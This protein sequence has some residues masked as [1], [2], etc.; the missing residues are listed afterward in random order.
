MIIE[1]DIA[2]S[3]SKV[4]CFKCQYC[5]NCKYWRTPVWNMWILTNKLCPASTYSFNSIFEAIENKK[6]ESQYTL[7]SAW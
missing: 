5:Y 7:S 1:E 4:P 6:L 3:L 2:G